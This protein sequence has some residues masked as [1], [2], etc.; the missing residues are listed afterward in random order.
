MARSRHL[1][2]HEGEEISI[3]TSIKPLLSPVCVS[4]NESQPMLVLK[5]GVFSKVGMFL[6]VSVFLRVGMSKVTKFFN[7]DTAYT[8]ASGLHPHR[9]APDQAGHLRIGKSLQSAAKLHDQISEIPIAEFDPESHQTDP[10]R[11]FLPVVAGRSTSAGAL[12][13]SGKGVQVAHPCCR[14]AGSN[15]EAH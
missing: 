1:I 5:V 13:T 15:S 7:I 8:F 2:E 4:L 11:P 12:K 6:K 10:E 14:D 3:P 9:R